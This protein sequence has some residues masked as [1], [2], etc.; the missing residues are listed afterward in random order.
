MGHDAGMCN[1]CSGGCTDRKSEAQTEEEVN[2]GPY[3]LFAAVLIVGLSIA[4]QWLL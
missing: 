2:A 1:K 3:L 4:I